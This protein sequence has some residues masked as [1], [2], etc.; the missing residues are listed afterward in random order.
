VAD[1][2]R[3][4]A[5]QAEGRRIAERI[6]GGPLLHWFTG[7]Y[8]AELYLRG[9]WEDAVHV[10]GPLVEQMASSRNPHFIAIP[11][12]AVLALIAIARDD[13]EGAERESKVALER[14][15]A[16]GDL[17]VLYTAFASRAVVLAETGRDDEARAIVSEFLAHQTGE[18]ER[19]GQAFTPWLARIMLAW[20]SLRFGYA[21]ELAGLLGRDP[22]PV[23]SP[24]AEME[25]PWAE[26]VKPILQA[27]LLTAAALAD[28]HL[29][30]P[31]AAWLRLQA[32]RAGDTSQLDQALAFYR[33]AGATRYVRE[34]EKRVTA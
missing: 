6:G 1:L 34:A 19:T 12:R 21:D 9:R 29:L 18:V 13:T 32:A 33:A 24:W 20:L 28:E 5:L 16:V 2:Q 7:E 23:G 8:A 15:R 3:S 17:Q 14:G 22:Q 25:S 30:L 10:G 26:M 31:D 27:D 4:F 11:T